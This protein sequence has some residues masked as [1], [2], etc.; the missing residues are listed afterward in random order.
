MSRKPSKLVKITWRD[1]ASPANDVW[2]DEGEAKKF[3][4]ETCWDCG[5]IVEQDAAYTT[6]IGG[7]SSSGDVHRLFSIPTKCI[8][9]V[10]TLKEEK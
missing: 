2:I 7:G 6:I 1:A 8:T 10:V 4:G 9:S 5:V 3:V